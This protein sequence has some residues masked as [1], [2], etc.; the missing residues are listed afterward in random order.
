MLHSTTDAESTPHKKL[1]KLTTVLKRCHR[2]FV[3]TPDDLNRLKSHG[4]VEN[5]AIFPHGIPDWDRE[6]S[7]KQNKTF[8]L[9]SYGFFLPHKGLLELIETFKIL[10]E[11]GLEIRLKMIN[12]Q[13]PVPLSLQLIEQAKEKIQALELDDHIEIRS[14][15]LSD[16]ACLKELSSS[17]L[18]IFPYQETGESSSAAVRYGIASG[19]PVAVTPLKI[20]DDVAPAVFK[21]SGTTPEEMATGLEQIIT[22]IKN[23]SESIQIKKRNIKRWSDTHKYSI[24]GKRLYN[25][26]LTLSKYKKYR[27]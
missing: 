16:E 17:D 4:L 9:A 2:I 13:Y 6:R 24:L 27:G 11:K 21:L 8:T 14:D 25:I 26:L 15:Y 18:I 20:F 12:A 23:D 1:S 10:K 19:T 7:E 5:I 22:D 3:H